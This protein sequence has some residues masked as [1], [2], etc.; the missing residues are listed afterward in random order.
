MAYVPTQ[1]TA[2]VEV[3]MRQ[4]NIPIE[5]VLHFVA[6]TAITQAMLDNLTQAV[7][8]Y[9]EEGPLATMNF[10]VTMNSV[11]AVDMGA[12]YGIFSEYTGDG[13]IEGA[14]AGFA[15][16][17]C[18]TKA[19]TLVTPIRGRSGR[20]RIFVCGLERT[21]HDTTR[22]VDGAL[23]AWLAA[24]SPMVGQDA[25]A[26]GWRLCIVSK[27]QGGAPRQNGLPIPVTKMRFSDPSLDVQR[28]RLE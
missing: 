22:C 12:Q 3:R 15:T 20:G 17:Q 10:S 2:E 16:A 13:P 11:Y 14:R 24:Y 4:T 8:D 28:G 7:W 23:T 1:N 9:Y 18:L 19:I 21:D 27:Q 25:V 26:P 6:N 5:N